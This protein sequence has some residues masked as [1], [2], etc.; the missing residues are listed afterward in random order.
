MLE[1]GPHVQHYMQGLSSPYLNHGDFMQREHYTLRVRAVEIGHIEGEQGKPDK[2][3]WMVYFDGFDKPLGL[4]AT[5]NLLSFVEMFGPNAAKWIGRRVTIHAVEEKNFGQ[6][7]PCVRVKGS[8][9]ITRKMSFSVRR[10]RKVVKGTLIQTVD[11]NAP[12]EAASLHDFLDQSGISMGQLDTWCDSI[13]KP[14]ASGMD[15]AGQSTVAVY[16]AK[17]PDVVA[18]VKAIGGAE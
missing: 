12:Q 5:V 6:M 4:T 8:P 18:A 1:K 13:S 7:G 10:G 2:K 15:K 3:P 11:E 17:N 14:P 9:E 16:L